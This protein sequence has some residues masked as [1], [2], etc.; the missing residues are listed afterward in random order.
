MFRGWPVGVS[1]HKDRET[2]GKTRG[3]RVISR[4]Q[5]LSG[6]DKQDGRKDEEGD[7]H[8]GA[9]DFL[10][11]IRQSGFSFQTF[12]FF[13]LDEWDV[14]ASAH[15]KKENKPECS[16][17]DCDRGVV[18]RRWK[19]LISNPLLC[20]REPRPHLPHVGVGMWIWQCALAPQLKG[21]SNQ[22]L[23]TGEFRCES[24]QTCFLSAAETILQS[25][26]QS[27]TD[28]FCYPLIC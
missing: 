21:P 7:A 20:L 11:A 2:Q 6:R 5:N 4:R 28:L 9:E 15:K 25:F 18:V 19:W 22:N 8:R 10:W 17:T 12:F 16:R 14:N 27:S 13:R 1:D 23:W 24:L 3:R 26:F